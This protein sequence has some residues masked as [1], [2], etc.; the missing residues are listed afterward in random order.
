MTKCQGNF[1]IN[2]KKMSLLKIHIKKKKDSGT[3]FYVISSLK[4]S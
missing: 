2:K 4:E 3:I 1:N